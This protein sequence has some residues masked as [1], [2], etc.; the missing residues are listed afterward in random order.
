[1]RKVFDFYNKIEERLLVYSLVFNVI[2]LF[3]QVCMRSIFNLSPSWSEE[4]SRYIFIWQ[5]WLGTSIALREGKHIKLDLIHQIIKSESVGK[6]IDAVGLIIWFVFSLFL[7]QNGTQL[8]LSII[9]R[10]ALSSGMRIPLF[11]VY[12]VLPF[13]S[14]VVA[15]RLAAQMYYSIRGFSM[16]E[17]G[18]N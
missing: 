11:L 9:N 6:I 17:G 13:S 14:L 12:M 8:T 10:H 4:L 5:T 16:G 15:C 3:F 18:N 1:M 2:L 7:L